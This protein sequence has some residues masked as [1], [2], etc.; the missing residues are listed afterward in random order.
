MA[1]KAAQIITERL[2]RFLQR[3]LTK[4]ELLQVEEMNLKTWATAIMSFIDSKERKGIPKDFRLIYG[5]VM[6]GKLRGAVKREVP[7]RLDGRLLE[8]YNDFTEFAG[9]GMGNA[10]LE[11]VVAMAGSY[12]DEELE[13][14]MR[15]SA[16]RGIRRIC[17]VRGIIDGNRR[18]ASVA[19]RRSTSRPISS[20]PRVAHSTQIVPRVD[21]IRKRWA[22]KLRESKAE[23]E[24]LQAERKAE[25]NANG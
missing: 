12:S 21:D 1:S 17:Y 8:V 9:D 3:K 10:E 2:E 16:A 15:V 25:R 19:M 14:A 23:A 20:L 18:A 22:E 11:A 24:L 6:R 4:A 7:L 13:S 5:P